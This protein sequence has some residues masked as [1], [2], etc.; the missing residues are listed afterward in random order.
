VITENAVALIEAEAD[1]VIEITGIAEAGTVHASRALESGKD[2]VMVNVETDALLGFALR[3]KADRLGRII[4]MAYGDQ[5]AIIC[6][7]YEGVELDES[8]FA[9][10]LRKG[11]EQESKNR[12]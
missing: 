8:G 7:H 1:V 4:S 2:V 10:G 6:E 11:M 9:Y 3:K 5:P 12:V